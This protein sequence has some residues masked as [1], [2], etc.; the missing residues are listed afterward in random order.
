[1]INEMSAFSLLRDAISQFDMPDRIAVGPQVLTLFKDQIGYLTKHVGDLGAGWE[2]YIRAPAF[3][4]AQWR[5]DVARLIRV[6]AQEADRTMKAQRSEILGYLRAKEW[7]VAMARLEQISAA[8][9]VMILQRREM[10]PLWRDL[11][12]Q[13]P[14]RVA[15]MAPFLLARMPKAPV[16]EPILRACV[17]S[18]LNAQA[19]LC[20]LLSSGEL[21]TMPDLI[22]EIVPL[23]TENLI[24]QGELSSWGAILAYLSTQAG[25]DVSAQIIRGFVSSIVRAD[26]CGECAHEGFTSALQLASEYFED[27]RLV[28]ALLAASALRQLCSSRKSLDHIWK[29]ATKNRA[30]QEDDLC[31]AL[32]TNTHRETLKAVQYLKEAQ[33]RRVVFW[34]TPHRHW[35]GLLDAC[36]I[37]LDIRDFSAAYA[38][39]LLGWADLMAD[40]IERGSAFWYE[41]PIVCPADSV[42][43][44]SSTCRLPLDVLCLTVLDSRVARI[45]RCL[46]ERAI[47]AT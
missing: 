1:M 26:L 14:E 41:T 32:P 31:V 47:L 11:S 36:A 38:R 13:L 7:E 42:G 44:P 10:V 21:D 28:T 27:D 5:R 24:A 15:A 6:L 8:S 40:E 39:F 20:W 9:C 30:I 16:A 33:Q 3:K 22:C 4:A 17:E 19:A 37:S 43:G 46:R 29:S 45:E 25:N 35:A 34:S 18:S 12:Y 23:A 2:L